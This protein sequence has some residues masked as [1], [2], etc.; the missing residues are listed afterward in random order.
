MLS[1]W[2]LCQVLNHLEQF[3][4]TVFIKTVNNFFL[5]NIS[6]AMPGLLYDNRT[7]ISTIYYVSQTVEAVQRWRRCVAGTAP[8]VVLNKRDLAVD[9]QLSSEVDVRRWMDKCA[10]NADVHVE[11]FQTTY[12][13]KTLWIRLY[14]CTS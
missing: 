1:L 5:V 9:A 7:N 11:L 13:L 2:W 12:S 3:I 10:A 6:I 8:E 14:L 4:Y